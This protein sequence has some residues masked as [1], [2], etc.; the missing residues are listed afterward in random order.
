MVE[1]G[2]DLCLP[3]RSASKGCP[4]WRCGLAGV[5]LALMLAS[6]VQAITWTFGD[7]DITPEPPPKGNSLHGYCEYVFHIYNRSTEQPHTV[8]LSIPYTKHYIRDD[9]IR[10]LRRT[11][12]VGANATVRLSLLQPDHPP[13]A[14]TDAEVTIDGRRQDREIQLHLAVRYNPYRRSYGYMGMIEPLILMGPH[15]QPFPTSES[16]FGG[17]VTISGMPFGGPGGPPLPAMGG[18]PPRMMPGGPPGPLPRGPGAG[19]QLDL[20]PEAALLPLVLPPLWDAPCGVAISL[21]IAEAGEIWEPDKWGAKLFSKAGLPARGFQFVNAETWSGDWLAYSRYDGIVIT[22][23]DL[24]EVPAEVR[25]ALWQY[26]ETGGALLVLGKSDLSGLS[27]VRADEDSKD[28]WMNVRAGLGRCRVSPDANY[29]KWDARHFEMLAKDWNDIAAAWQGRGDLSSANQQ[30]PVIDDFGIPIRGLFVLMFLFTLAIGPIN[31]LVLTYK[32]RRL[33]MLWTTPAISLFTC[34]AVF[35]YMLISEGWQGRLHTDTLTLLDETTHRATTVGQTGVYSPL[36]PGD[37]LHF[38]YQTEVTSLQYHPEGRGAMRSCTIDLSRD[39]H[40]A[41]GWVEAR[42]PAL[43]KIRKSE[44]RRERVALQRERDGRW[45]MVNGL[46]AAIRRFWY[47]DDKG[48]IHTGEDIAAGARTLL[49]PTE[50]ETPVVGLSLGGPLSGTSWLNSMR[51]L[52]DKPQEYLRP[53]NYLAEVDESPF[54]DDPLRQAK[55]R[56]VHALIVGFRQ[57]EK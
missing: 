54:L 30:F 32:K 5:L 29:A 2:R 7:L 14:G 13:I 17:G 8:S 48:Q 41:T 45:S 31:L 49:N 43:F 6:P 9:A 50:K 46:S 25:T 52:T 3:A 57:Q 37:G 27:A 38:D 15:V 12:Q 42:V 40:F 28:G 56:K 16:P 36:T 53:G 34:L 20:P 4:C 22:A 10:E 18:A 24:K 35:G 51:M 47:A 11:V 19:P 21:A 33:W 39:Q 23:A 1:M 55:N 26:V 44:Q